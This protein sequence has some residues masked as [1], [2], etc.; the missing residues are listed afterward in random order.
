MLKIVV[1]HLEG[2]SEKL[3]QLIIY[4][5]YKSRKKCYKNLKEV[6]QGKHSVEEGRRAFLRMCFET[7]GADCF[8]KQRRGTKER[9]CGINAKNARSR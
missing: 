2:L 3:I 5:Y 7:G 4:D 6:T 1:E 9:T 8:V